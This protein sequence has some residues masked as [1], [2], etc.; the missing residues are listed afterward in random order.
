METQEVPLVTGRHRNRALAK[1]RKTRAVELVLNGCTYQQV[2]EQMG[3]ANRG[4]VHRLVN[5]TLAEHQVETVDDLRALEVARLDALQ[6]AYWDRAISG[7]DLRAAAFVLKI[8]DR[9]AKMLGLYQTTHAAP[10][11]GK[12]SQ[13]AS[14]S[15]NDDDVMLH[16]GADGGISEMPM[17]A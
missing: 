4:T 2:A 1:R 11:G 16:F 14:L 12:A 10:R 8:L 17:P 7:K 13:N 6:A 15:Y 9:R 5:E 3:Y